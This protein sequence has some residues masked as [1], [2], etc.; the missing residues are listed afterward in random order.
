YALLRFAFPF[1]QRPLVQRV[2]FPGLCAFT[3]CFSLR[4]ATVGSA[5]GYR[6]AV[7]LIAEQ[8]LLNN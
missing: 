1:G 2:I 8:L 3:L 4:P 6:E 5:H 7:N